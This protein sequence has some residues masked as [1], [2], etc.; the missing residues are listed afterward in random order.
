MW[1]IDEG[2]KEGLVSV[3]KALKDRL[4]QKPGHEVIRT[5][6]FDREVG[7]FRQC[8]KLD[9]EELRRITQRGTVAGTDGSTNEGGGKYPYNIT[10]QRALAKGC[11]I[12]GREGARDILEKDDSGEIS[13][14]ETLSPLITDMPVSEDEYRRKVKQNL[15]ALEAKAAVDYIKKYSPS[16]M[17]IDGSL[18]RLKIEAA[19]LWEELKETALSWRSALCGVVEGISTGAIGEALRQDLPEALFQIE[20]WELLS[21]L[22][23]PGEVLEVRPGLFKEGFRTCFARFTFDPKPIGIDLLEEQQDELQDLEDLLYTLT[24]EGG[25]GIPL[26]LDIIDQKVRITDKMA[27]GL[28]K[29]YLGEAHY[30]FISEKRNERNW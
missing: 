10:V 26:W 4:A 15:A 2:L 23:R 27:E 8:R 5:L 29:L 17:L 3:T 19:G 25:R 9:G 11:D 21:G 7:V 14:S 28:L 12:G 20:D 13:L 6:I 24:P 16:V 1:K 22:M 30:E 18:V